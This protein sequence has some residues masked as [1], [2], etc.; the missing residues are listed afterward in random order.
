MTKMTLRLTKTGTL[1][2]VVVVVLYL[3]ALTS[4]SGLLLLPVGIV[5][6][7]FAVNL[8]AAWWGL[9]GL[10]L[11][12]PRSLHL[13]EGQRLWQPWRLINHGA[14]PAGFVQVESPAG[15]LARASLLG[16]K[17]ECPL[18]PDLVYCRRGVYAHDQLQL[19]SAYPFGFVKASRAVKLPGEIVV[20]P[21]LFEVEP[22]R[23]SGYDVMVG[24]KHHGQRRT[25]SGVHFAGVRPF[26]AGDPLKQI[27]WRSSAK[28]LG[29]M[30]KTHDEELSGRVAL[31]TDSGHTGDARTLDDAMRATGSLIFAALEAGHHVEWIDLTQLECRLIPPFADGHDVLE[32]LARVQLDPGCLTAERLRLAVER[33]SR[34]A[35]LHLVVTDLPPPV[36]S[37][38][39]ALR[40]LNRSVWVYVPE[41]FQG[42]PNLGVPVLRYTARGLTEQAAP[43]ETAA[44]AGARPLD[45]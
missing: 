14:H 29:L 30:V 13:S 6:G 8:A 28:G 9:R 37:A 10:E 20:Y 24:G 19:T 1:F 40:N 7:C 16:P 11:Q 23:A 45:A 18:V 17:Q 3:A 2:L 12:V 44:P 26:Q 41:H 31:V 5:L 32:A 15:L 39:E 33:V 25:S 21:A 35:A 42:A 38:V 43:A 34:K 4:Q 27:H 22:P 36:R